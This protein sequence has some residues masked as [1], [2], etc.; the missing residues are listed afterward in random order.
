[1]IDK[2]AAGGPVTVSV[3]SGDVHHSYAA[4]AD[5]P[6]AASA[7]V[8]QLTCSPVHNTMSWMIKPGFRLGWSR[9]VG[10]LASRWAARVGAPPMPL[11]WTRLTG[12]LFGNM[13]ATLDIDGDRASVLFEQPRTA[14]TLNELAR[15]ELTT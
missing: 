7:R 10:R 14:A 11:S 2:A 3:L 12:P 6:S 15:L 4:R 5:L 9:T 8:H 1:M 13:I